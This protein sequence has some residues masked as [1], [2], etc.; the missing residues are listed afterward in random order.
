MATKYTIPLKP[1]IIC[2]TSTVFGINRLFTISQALLIC[3]YSIYIA[4]LFFSS[5]FLKLCP[6]LL[7]ILNIFRRESRRSEFVQIFRFPFTKELNSTIVLW[8]EFR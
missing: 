8:I 2:F 3:L 1:Q 6:V 4:I 5:K 7:L